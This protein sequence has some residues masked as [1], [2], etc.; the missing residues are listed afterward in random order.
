MKYIC[1]FLT[2]VSLLFITGKTDCQDLD[3]RAY[4]WIPVNVSVAVAGFTYSD[5]G[6]VTDATLPLED[7]HAK[8]WIP[9][10][11]FVRSFPLAGRTAQVSAA[12][13]YAW[14]DA[15]GS[16]LGIAQSTSRSGLSDM[17]LRFS[18]L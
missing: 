9:S 8:I 13:P 17:R 14:G 10:L 4:T 11:A 16:I 6:I 18:W 12:L 15:S 5:G 1:I 7:L 2:A 3:P